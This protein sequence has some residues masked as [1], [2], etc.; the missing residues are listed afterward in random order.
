MGTL[1]YIVLAL[2]YRRFIRE[3]YQYNQQ[4]TY[5]EKM[6]IEHHHVRVFSMIVVG[7]IFATL[8]SYLLTSI[9][10]ANFALVSSIF[11]FP[12]DL[13]PFP[14]NLSGL[15]VIGFGLLLNAYANYMLLFVGK[16]GLRDRE[17]FHTPSTLVVDG[18]YRF[19]RNPVYLSV[20][21]MIFGL[22]IVLSSLLLIIL[23]AV[24]HG[25]F[26]FSLIRWEERRLEEALGIDYLEYKKHVRRWL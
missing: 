25:I 2:L 8:L 13:I 15:F 19:S 18:P 6:K 10:K 22:A 17:P 1:N 21:I 11:L 12:V 5:G 24:V 7:L 14:Y 26:Q 23:L 20:L 3:V 4:I 16:I 9:L